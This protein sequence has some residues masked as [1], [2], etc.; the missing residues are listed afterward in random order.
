MIDE[1]THRNASKFAIHIYENPNLLF[2]FFILC[3]FTFS[4]RNALVLCQQ[5]RPGHY[6]V[7]KVKLHELKNGKRNI[8][9]LYTYI[10]YGK[11]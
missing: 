3:Y 4:L 2:L 7:K 8:W 1:M 9:F 6:L 11:F 5:H 10:K